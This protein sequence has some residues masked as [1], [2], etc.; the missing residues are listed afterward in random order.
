MGFVV[1]DDLNEGDF[2]LQDYIVDSLQFIDFI[3]RLEKGFGVTLP[4]DFLDY[5]VTESLFGF[6][7]ML[8]EYLLDNNIGREYV[9]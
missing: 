7:S 8:E 2:N 6:A 1:F 5:S 9:S 3:V 4:D